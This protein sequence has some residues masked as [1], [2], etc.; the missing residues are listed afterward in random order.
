MH[1]QRR[2][3]LPLVILLFLVGCGAPTVGN[4]PTALPRTL[5]TPVAAADTTELPAATS[6]PSDAASP[7]PAATLLP[8]DIS[9]TTD[10]FLNRMLEAKLFSGSVLIARNDEILLSKGYGMADREERIPNTPQTKFRIGSIT[11]QFTAMAILI[12][13][14]QGK[15]NVQDAI[16]TYISDCPAAWQPITIHQLLTHTSGIPSFTRFPE[17]LTIAKLSLTPAEMI[18]RIANKP[19]DF[20]PGAE[21]SYSNSGYY[22]LGAII[23]RASG[24]SYEAFLQEHIFAPLKMIDTG[25]EHDKAMLATGYTSTLAKADDI[26]MSIP[27]AS[28]SL[29]STVEDIYRWHQVLYTEQLVSTESLDKMFTAFV[30]VPE[31]DGYGYGY[32]WFIDKQFNRQRNW[33]DG[34]INGFQ[35]FAS[36]YPDE[37][38]SIILFSNREATD[39]EGFEKTLA[40]LVFGEK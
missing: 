23:E 37:R 10:A 4:A 5:P 6:K 35:D 39:T 19:L 1:T 8:S 17:Y 31:A 34:S 33:H 13:Q 2:I 28:G 14:A 40:K 11:K 12:L 16:C 38:V 25:Y 9:S 21:W 27:Y 24:Q 20:I 7:L 26:N 18:A 30:P 36:R 15:L 32:A 3:L 22:L 29:Y